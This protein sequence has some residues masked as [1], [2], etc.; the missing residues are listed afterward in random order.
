MATATAPVSFPLTLI[1]ALALVDFEFPGLH[2]AERAER[3]YQIR[4]DNLAELESWDPYVPDEDGSD[5][6]VRHLE[7][8][9]YD[10]ARFQEQMEAQMG[11]PV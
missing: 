6:Y 3:A 8:R 9:G 10:E 1:A 5:A 11:I 2:W 7:L 4:D